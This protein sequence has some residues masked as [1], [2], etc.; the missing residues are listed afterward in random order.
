[1]LTP[2]RGVGRDVVAPAFQLIDSHIV[3]EPVH[4][5]GSHALRERSSR[6]YHSRRCPQ[7]ALMPCSWTICAV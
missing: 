7:P 5:D 3:F 1:M 4:R 2:L 6:Q